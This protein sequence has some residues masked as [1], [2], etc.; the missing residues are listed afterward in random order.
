MLTAK[1]TAA[2]HE[3]GSYS[4]G[5]EAATK[6]PN[7]MSI[8]ICSDDDLDKGPTVHEQISADMWKNAQEVKANPALVREGVPR[9][10][11]LVVHP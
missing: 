9:T 10:A 2:A 1:S 11:S 8:E 4:S 6:T 5:G 3:L 7:P